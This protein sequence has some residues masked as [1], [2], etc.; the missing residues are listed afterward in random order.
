MKHELK[1]TILLLALFLASQI[2][3]LAII[4]QYID[5]TAT[6]AT[7]VATFKE[8][9]YQIERPE[10]EETSSFSYILIA[11]LLGTALLLFLI[12]LKK[13][14]FLRLWFFLVVWICL[15]FAF[16]AFIP[17]FIAL[18]IALVIAVWRIYRP[19]IIIHNAAEIFI[20]GGLAAIFVP[21]M[22]IFAA[23]MLLLLISIYDMIAVW[24]SKH[25]IKLAKFQ[26]KSKIFAGMFL[27]YKLKE[28]LI[29]PKKAKPAPAKAEKIVNVKHAILGGGDI[30][31]PLLFAGVV[32]KG[33]MLENSVLIGFLKTLAIPICVTIALMFLFIKGEKDKFYPA[34]PF[35][36]IGCLAGYLIIL[37]INLL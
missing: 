30:G 17:Q 36:S 24:K 8:L 1:I 2:V 4:N 14:I 11:I 23:F 26:T 34:M 9:P 22:N 18:I 13:V 25:M 37:G 21:L 3:G 35:L 28:G 29:K 31:F 19:N 5:H 12:K 33:L 7:G 15:S 27:P 20:Y 16:S 10:I 32:M 6:A